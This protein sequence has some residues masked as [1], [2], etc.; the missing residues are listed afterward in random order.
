MMDENGCMCEGC[1]CKRTTLL[2]TAVCDS[3]LKGEHSNESILEN[4]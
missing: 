1:D 4:N 2:V 3:C